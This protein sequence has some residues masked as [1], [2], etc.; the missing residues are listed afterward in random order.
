VCAFSVS[1]CVGVRVWGEVSARMGGHGRGID[2]RPAG[3]FFFYGSIS[4][5]N[6]GGKLG[7][8]VGEQDGV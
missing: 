5:T 7:S 6:V 8:L 2:R 1:A 4:L 3:N